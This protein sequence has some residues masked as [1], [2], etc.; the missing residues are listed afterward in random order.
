MERWKYFYG[1]Y[2]IVN[3]LETSHSVHVNGVFINLYSDFCPYHK[4]LYNKDVYIGET[5]DL[6]VKS[7]EL[8]R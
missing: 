1:R 3:K 7:E 6:L 4:D 8:E 2:Y 5:R